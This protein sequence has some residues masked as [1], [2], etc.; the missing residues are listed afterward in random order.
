ME[1]NLRTHGSIA[2]LIIESGNFKFK[3]DL[4][5]FKNGTYQI[6]I[7]EIENFIT[8]A[9]EMHAFNGGNDVEFVKMIAE[10]FLT[11]SELKQLIEQL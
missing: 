9:K 2:E 5:I 6:H 8:I 3:E 1:L 10:A 4:A 11:N 7:S